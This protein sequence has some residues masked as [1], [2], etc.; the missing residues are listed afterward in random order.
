MASDAAALTVLARTAKASW[1][2]ADSCLDAWSAELTITSEYIERHRV[3][4]ANAGSDVAGMC[5]LEHLG[6]HWMLEHV[7]VAPAFQHR[8]LGSA[9]VGDAIAAARAH[10]EGVIRV[11]SDPHAQVFYET[12]GARV[13]GWM[14][15][16]I[17]GD[18]ERRLPMM[19]FS[20]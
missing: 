14:P 15:A 12:L 20:P 3:M 4:V 17:E 19:E 6:D 16:P 18:A 9:L 13:I 1:G 8:G 2:Y 11:L 7:W 10:S 5:A